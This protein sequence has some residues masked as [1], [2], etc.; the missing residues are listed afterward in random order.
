MSSNTRIQVVTVAANPANRV[1]FVTK[2]SLRWP[3][4]VA[5]AEF[6]GEKL[7]SVLLRNGA[8]RTLYVG[9]GTKEKIQADTLRRAAG[10]AVKQLLKIGA[11]EIA[12]ELDNWTDKAQAIVEGALIAA[13][14]FE[15]FKTPDSRRKVSLKRLLLVTSANDQARVKKFVAAGEILA[16]A[17]NFTRSIGNQPAN[18]MTPAALA[19]EARALARDCDLKCT[20]FDEKRLQ[21]DK[22]G[23]I[24]AVGQGSAAAPRLIVLEYWG[25]GKKQKPVALVGKAITFDTGG[26]SLKPGAQMDE[27]KFDK[28][29]GCAVLGAMQAISCLNLP[30][31]VVGLIP[32]AENMPSDRAYRPGDIVTTYDG[33]TIEVLNTDAEGRVVLV[34]ALAY[35]RLTYKPRY[36]V[37]FATLTGACVVAL[38]MNRAGL[39][40]D[41]AALR[42]SLLA[43][44][45]ETGDS[46]WELPLAEDYDNDVK[47]DVATAKNTGNGRWAGAC[48]AASFLKIW[49]GDVPWAH[50]DIAGTAW[51]TSD[52]PYIEKGATG[53]GVRLIVDA[54]QRL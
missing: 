9:L 53:F 16:E 2:E 34:D 52:K 29:G 54:L 50:L 12:I 39:F 51:T 15:D 41:T 17:T 44:G 6:E 22:F 40:T 11:E 46:L 35:A 10:V 23:G 38:G 48:T 47:S 45:A 30:I 25:A 19:E 4:D 7:T 8:E 37:D 20:I 42:E 26:I 49:A 18:I 5:K 36:M 33:K 24:L 28:M 21:R 43:A 1:I 13:Y 32:A 27:M 31:N 3:K 14:R